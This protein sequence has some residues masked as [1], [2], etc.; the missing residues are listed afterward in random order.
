MVETEGVLKILVKH[1][2]NLA[3]RD[4]FSSDPYVKLSIGEHEV[5]TRVIRRDLNPEWNEE[6]T[7]PVPSPPLPLKLLVL[8]KDLFKADDTMGDAEIDLRPLSAAAKLKEGLKSFQ[9]GMN[10]RRV[11]AN[12]VNGFVKDSVIKF[13]DGYIVQE[14]LIKLQH[15]EKGQIELE[16]KWQP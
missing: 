4:M 12:N 15:V 3:I 11:V 9:E 8:D 13:K 2:M 6:L 14:V 10:I 7:L 16:L 5:K 1:G